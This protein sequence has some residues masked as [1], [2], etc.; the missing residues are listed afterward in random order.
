MDLGFSEIGIAG[1]KLE[2]AVREM[3]GPQPA[4]VFQLHFA[5]AH[6]DV[7]AGDTGLQRSIDP[8]QQIELAAASFEE[9]S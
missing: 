2:R 7:R 1:Q 8:R 6:Y 4:D 5:R 9:I 3:S